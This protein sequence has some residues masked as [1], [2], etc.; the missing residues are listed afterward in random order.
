MYDNSNNQTLNDGD[1]IL[2]AIATPAD[3]GGTAE[4]TGT[5]IPQVDPGGGGGTA[6]IKEIAP[7]G[8][9]IET[10]TSD[11]LP[12]IAVVN[13]SGNMGW[14]W[15]AL[16][17]VAV[18]VAQKS[19]VLGAVKKKS[20][21]VPLLLLGGAGTAV[22]LYMKSQKESGLPTTPSTTSTDTGGGMG[23]VGGSGEVPPIVE[24]GVD[25]VRDEQATLSLGNL[26]T[27]YPQYAG[28]YYSMSNE[29]LNTLWSYFY[30]YQSNGYDPKSGSYANIPLYE[31]IKAMNS[32]Y[33]LNLSI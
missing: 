21:L 1:A 4:A 22:Y 30:L 28:R 16:G 29:E 9:A 7:G 14:L 32:K 26:N 8:V 2:N 33:S 18:A 23:P 17:V 15:A 11:V 25:Y 20:A 24:H 27:Y 13:D 12:N 6:T 5:D 31:Y 19:G 10:G 3:L